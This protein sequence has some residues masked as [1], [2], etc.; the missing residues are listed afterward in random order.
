MPSIRKFFQYSQ[1]MF[2]MKHD[3]SSNVKE[4]NLNAQS[5]ICD[6][7]I[8]ASPKVAHKS[9]VTWWQRKQNN[10]GSVLFMS[11]FNIGDD[12]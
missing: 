11:D 7:L 3:V 8:L 5:N 12:F 1:K 4:Q 10:K 6:Q 9:T 2:W